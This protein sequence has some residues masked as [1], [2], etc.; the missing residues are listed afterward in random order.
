[1][2]PV[3]ETMV[4]NIRCIHYTVDEDIIKMSDQNGT[5]MATHAQG[6]I[7]VAHQSGIP[8]VMMRARIQMQ[9]SGVFSPSLVA[10]AIATPIAQDTNEMVYIVEYEVTDINIPIIIEPPQMSPK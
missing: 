4:S 2:K 7:W 6:D 3:G 9:I 1:M 10:T 5:T 8:L